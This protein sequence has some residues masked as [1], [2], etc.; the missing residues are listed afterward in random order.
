[1]T[2]VKQ[3]LG[4]APR[5]ASCH[6]AVIDGKI[7]EGHV[8]AAQVIELSKRDDLA[9][10]AVPGM[11]AGSPDMEVDGT[12]HA[13]QMI[14]LTKAGT[15]QVIATTPR[16]NPP[17]KPST[18]SLK[19]WVFGIITAQSFALSPNSKYS[20]RR[21]GPILLA[22]VHRPVSIRQGSRSDWAVSVF[23]KDFRSAA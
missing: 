12:Q 19:G 18:H 4:V 22:S 2:S 8:P 7:V 6:T 11:P 1:M 15:D 5:L 9:D 14:G 20:T 16:S 17:L 3:R 10:I 13:Y 23:A 21:Q